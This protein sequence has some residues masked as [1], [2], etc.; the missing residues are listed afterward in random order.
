MKIIVT[1]SA[2]QQL[3]RMPVDRSKDERYDFAQGMERIKQKTDAELDY[4][5]KDLNETIAIQE[6]GEREGHH[7]P[8][9]GF[10][11]DDLHCALDEKRKRQQGKSRAPKPK[12]AVPN[13]MPQQPSP[14][15]GV[16]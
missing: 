3:E 7:F 1:Q 5:I 12:A 8:K 6:K 9:L 10:Y 15:P 4:M 11:W 14:E 2:M 13:A 16:M